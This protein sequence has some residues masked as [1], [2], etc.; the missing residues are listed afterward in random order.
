MVVQPFEF[1]YHSDHHVVSDQ[2]YNFGTFHAYLARQVNVWG[3]IKIQNIAVECFYELHFW[4]SNLVDNKPTDITVSV[5][6]N[7]IIIMPLGRL[8]EVLN[9]NK[10]I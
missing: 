8:F 9:V 2:S 4:R 5:N 6:K 1:L 3:I 10:P 7:V